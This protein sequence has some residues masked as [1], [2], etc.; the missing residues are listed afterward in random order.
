[1]AMAK[2]PNE[3]QPEPLL[4]A[5][6]SSGSGAWMSDE[7][8]KRIEAGLASVVERLS[9]TIKRQDSFDASLLRIADKVDRV[10]TDNTAHSAMLTVQAHIADCSRW[11]E[12]IRGIVNDLKRGMEQAR[13]DEAD[14]IKAQQERAEREA[15][16][17][18]AWFR[19]L[20]VVAAGALLTIGGYFAAALLEGKSLVDRRHYEVIGPQYQGG[21]ADR[22][23]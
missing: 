15:R 20:A 4:A 1:M 3:F 5:E 13:K 14:E 21:T 10:L 17:R 22:N 23:E 12:D 8:A 11:R 7:A 6:G 16:E 18:R 2:A 9:D 19:G